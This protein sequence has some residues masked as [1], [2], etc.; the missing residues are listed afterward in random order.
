V[1]GGAAA[2]GVA[3]ADAFATTLA[4]GAALADAGGALRSLLD[5]FAHAA[6]TIAAIGAH[7][8]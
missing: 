7:A 1:R 4:V 3:L 6:T 2:D 5:S 8:R